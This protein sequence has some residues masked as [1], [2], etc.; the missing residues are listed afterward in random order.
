MTDSEPNPTQPPT[1]AR[2]CVR[3]PVCRQARR[4]Q[5]GLA[6]WLVNKVERKLC[7]FGRAYERAFGR[8]PHEP[9]QP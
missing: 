8:K 7:V 3:C 5:A 4:Q 9:I 1:L 2:V 6:Y